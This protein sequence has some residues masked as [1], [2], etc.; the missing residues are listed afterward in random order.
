MPDHPLKLIWDIIVLAILIINIIYIPMK[1]SFEIE[2]TNDG[3]DFFLET[4]P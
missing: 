3:L 2:N 4:L 1:I